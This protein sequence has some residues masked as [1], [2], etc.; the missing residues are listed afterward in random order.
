MSRFEREKI[1]KKVHTASQVFAG[2]ASVGILIIVLQLF[3]KTTGIDLFN[4]NY[5]LSKLFS[6]EAPGE[7][8]TLPSELNTESSIFK[9]IYKNQF[10][11]SELNSTAQTFLQN[12]ITVSPIKPT[13]TN[14][15]KDNTDNR[16][17]KFLSIDIPS[18]HSTGTIFGSD[19][20]FRFRQNF[21]QNGILPIVKDVKYSKWSVGIS[22]A[23]GISFSRIKY[24]NIA[25]ISTRTVGNTQYGF[26]QTQKER[27]EMNRSLMKYS[28]SLDISYRFNNSLSLQS[29]LV[30]LN[31]GESVLVKEITDENNP[32]TIAVYEPNQNHFFEGKPDFE[33]PESA[34]SENNVRFA[35]NLSFFE[36]PL[37][38]NYKVRSID[39]LT[40][41]ELQAGMSVTRLDFVSAMV[42]N[43]ENNGYYLITGSQPS[44][45]QKFGSNAIAG[46]VLNKYITNSIQFFVNPQFKLGLTNNFDS[47]YN[48][49]Q[50]YHS[51]SVR[52]GMK[53]NL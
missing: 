35:N 36:I 30:Y 19:L 3:S 17:E 34:S 37:I 39:K 22:L 27:N 45:Y 1:S 46:V 38:L 13:G 33:S 41:I 14:E 42:Y 21:N 12:N 28:L 11:N 49:K 26:Y 53:I 52:L 48:I 10:E 43:F 4:I 44:I 24:T 7:Q 29:G 50:H 20:Q 40:E 2:L 18:V 6:N 31:S 9:P 32:Q 25:S 5:S 23:P 15:T 47:G 51:A 16:N 8:R